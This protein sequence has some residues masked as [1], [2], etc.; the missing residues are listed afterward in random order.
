MAEEIGQPLAILHVGLASR[1]LLDVVSV[2]Q[3][4][5]DLDL[6][7]VPDRLPVHTLVILRAGS[8][9]QSVSRPTIT[10]AGVPGSAPALAFRVYAE[11][12]GDFNHQEA[13]STQSGFAITNSGDVP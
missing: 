10:Q 1:Y 5:F 2:H 8:Q 4:E 12:S 3:Q 9:H 6:Q 7:E 11:A 13:G